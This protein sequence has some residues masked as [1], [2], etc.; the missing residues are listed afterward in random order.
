MGYVI[1][2]VAILPLILGIV[3]F[4]KEFGVQGKYSRLAAVALGFVFYGLLY[5]NESGLMPAAAMGWVNLVV[6]ALAGGLGAAGL[7]DLGKRFTAKG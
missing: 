2:G 5:A 3:E 7:Y 1:A 4:L 6:F